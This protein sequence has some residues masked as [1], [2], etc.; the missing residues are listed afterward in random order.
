MT[1]WPRMLCAIVCWFLTVLL[2]ITTGTYFL[3]QASLHASLLMRLFQTLVAGVVVLVGVG[4]TLAFW[5]W[6]WIKDE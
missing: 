6:V 1:F 4:I 2:L 3:P 5:L